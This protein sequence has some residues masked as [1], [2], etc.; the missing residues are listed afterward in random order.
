MTRD[1]TNWLWLTRRRRK[2][3][4]AKSIVPPL[5]HVAQPRSRDCCTELTEVPLGP[6]EPARA[7]LKRL[8]QGALSEVKKGTYAEAVKNP[9]E[10]TT[11][12][13][14]FDTIPRSMKTMAWA[15][16]SCCTAAPQIAVKRVPMTDPEFCTTQDIRGAKR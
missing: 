13:P 2:V 3:R 16:Y 9:S 7:A 15:L 5:E 10:T 12:S 8:T 11:P 14:T 4:L 1:F 6:L